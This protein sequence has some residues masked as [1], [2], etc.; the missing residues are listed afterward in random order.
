MSAREKATAAS[1][2]KSSRPEDWAHLQAGS[3]VA[4]LKPVAENLGRRVLGQQEVLDRLMTGFSRTLS[5]LRDPNR[6]LL[7]ALLLGPTGVGKTETAR[8]LA[9]GLFGSDRALTRVDGEE[10]AHGHEVSKLMGAPPGYVGHQVE[11]LLTQRRIDAPHRALRESPETGTPGRRGLADRICGGDPEC[12]ASVVLFDEIEKADPKVWSGLLGI[13]D[14][15]IVTLGDNTTTDFRHSIILMTSNVGSQEMA[16][17]IDH[18]PLG[19]GGGAGLGETGG[20][21]ET[22]RKAAR[23]HFPPEFLNRFDEVLVYRPLTPETLVGIFDKFLDE[24]HARAM[25]NA[26]IPLLI[27][28]SDAA[29]E[30]VLKHG[31]DAR[32]GARP[33]RRAFEREVVGPL[34]HLIA[35]GTLEK[36]DVVHVEREVD[37]LEFF[38]DR[39]SGSKLVA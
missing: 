12:F 10:Y 4:D 25:N 37:R 33:L 27:K 24:L 19:F 30:L 22:A 13:L 11:S 3:G 17:S 6:P 14:E 7:T 28:V 2:R 34:S 23:K 20:V 5:G 1:R 15:G 18:R 39:R 36:G 21:E 35:A 32:F 31:T 38:R 29:R 16:D 8:A 9:E 26:G